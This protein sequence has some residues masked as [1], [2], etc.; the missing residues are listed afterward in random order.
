[1]KRTDKFSRK[2][3]RAGLMCSVAGL[4]A[5]SASSAT[6]AQ[7][8]QPD[9]ATA[10]QASD[11]TAPP[12]QED[13]TVVVV[14]GTS[15]RG[16]PPVGAS[17]DT[18]SRD[19]I[20]ATAAT[21]VTELLRSAPEIGSFNTTGGNTGRDQANFVDQPAIHGVGV[22]NGGGGLT[23]V[24]VNG[25][26]L[27]GAGINQTAPDPSS[28]PTSALQR[29][30]V[31]ADGASSIYGSDAIAGVINFITLKK[32]DGVQLSGTT[33]FGDGYKSNNVSL[34]G[35]KSWST[36]SI[37]L[38]LESSDNT[39]INGSER[40]YYGDDQSA[41]GGP[42]TRATTCAP[43]VITSGASTYAFTGSAYAAT[44]DLAKCDL[45]KNNDLYPSNSRR[46]GLISLTQNLTDNIQFSSTV[47]YSERAVDSVVSMT[48]GS[49]NLVTTTVAGGAPHDYAV[50]LG[51]PTG[52]HTI[53][54]NPTADFGPTLTDPTRTSTLSA[55]A[56][57]DI[58]LGGDWHLA[59]DA[60]YG[61]EHD[62]II[63][64]SLN[65]GLLTSA[66]QSGAFNP[67]GV[68]TA[69]SQA[70]KDQ[71]ADYATRY[72][73]VQTV[74]E[75][76]AKIDG[77][78]FEMPGGPLKVAVGV[79]AR[80]ETFDAKALIGASDDL[81]LTQ[82]VGKRKSNSIY[83]EAVIPFVG[84]ANAIPGIYKLDVDLSARYDDYDDV[85]NTT[86]PKIGINYMPIEDLTLRTS[87]GSSFHAPSLA[88][89]GTAIDTRAI[90]FA[91]FTGS[92]TPG[93]YSIILA[94]GNTL[95]PETAKTLS[96]G[97]DYKPS[98][99]PGL[100]LS[101]T[102]F[103]IDYKNVI[104]FPGFNPVSEPNNPL[105][106]K[107]RIYNPTVAQVTAALGDMRHDGLVYPDVT[108]LPTAVYDLRR[109]NFAEQKIGGFDFDLQY[110]VGGL[111]LGLQGTYLN[112]FDQQINGDTTVSSRLDTSYAVKL[113]MRASVGY[114]W[115][116]YSAAGFINY[117]GKYENPADANA[118]VDAFTTVDFNLRRDFEGEG[119]DKG[120]SLYLNVSNLF[121]QD[122]PYYWDPSN[123]ARGYDA[124][125][126]SPL[127]RVVSVGL[128]KKW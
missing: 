12:A 7:T 117:T 18:I 54:Y 23:L 14:T 62:D 1:M 3:L 73:G 49:A 29:V 127:G 36:G 93:A 13:T 68:G 75:V 113:K 20:K 126:G 15:I 78:L 2:A 33:A 53:T 16:K 96:A 38:D 6:M 79:N 105:F 111:G 47:L 128:S 51:A 5:L 9:A 55:V 70:L 116:S 19:E 26:R 86:N 88:D 112:K 77:T 122:P 63:L 83:A 44:T 91:D 119:M 65:T 21:N 85:G 48:N 57:F 90:R 31:I 108:L 125:R 43:A 58:K 76:N 41:N 64:R 61:R 35:G 74:K 121:D 97:F 8:A 109:Q 24:L 46:Q 52:T 100:K 106:D 124:S 59:I 92:T 118:D 34:L 81:A 11:T 103:A 115:G 104:T 45:N 94:G 123:G 56:G 42:D 101:L 95:K 114:S 4:V 28:I 87:V 17:I 80:E 30:E 32:F 69:N 37:V 50:S 60:N 10:A 120:L 107:Y 72:I 22:G 99:V 40:S 89:S 82:T 25:H 39:A 98:S 67:Y 27:P 66:I 110:K 71:I 102:Y 84:D